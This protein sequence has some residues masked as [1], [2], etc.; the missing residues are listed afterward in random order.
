MDVHESKRSKSPSPSN[1]FRS[2]NPSEKGEE[3]NKNSGASSKSPRAN[4]K[5]EVPVPNE[6]SS[7]TKEARV[8]RMIFNGQDIHDLDEFQ[9]VNP[10]FKNDSAEADVQ[11]PYG[12]LPD[13]SPLN[14]NRASSSDEMD[15][16]ESGGTNHLFFSKISSTTDQTGRCHGAMNIHALA[17]SSDLELDKDKDKSKEDGPLTSESLRRPVDSSPLENCGLTGLRN[18]GNTCFMNSVLQCLSNT[19]PL[20]EYMLITKGYLADINTTTSTM[21][22]S[23]IKAY[24]KLIQDLW[25]E[26]KHNDADTSHLKGQIQKFAPVF[27]GA[28]QHDSQELLRFLLEGL[29]NDVNRVVV[30]PKLP[31]LEMKDSLDDAEKSNIAWLHYQKYDNS[32][33]MNFDNILYRFIL[34]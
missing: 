21:K 17:S 29:H 16:S 7:T 5:A 18:I 22:G 32:K 26:G 20:L 19:R 4:A 34:H 6:T 10:D 13:T 9:F 31:P 25:S 14:S 1:P 15:D 11:E 27:R 2:A 12:L 30:K 23:L 24:G 33:V 28:R 8:G 3:N